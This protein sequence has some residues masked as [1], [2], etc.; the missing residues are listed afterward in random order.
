MM[1]RPK[2]QQQFVG[3]QDALIAG[4]AGRRQ[5]EDDAIGQADVQLAADILQPDGMKFIAGEPM[6][7]ATNF[8]AGL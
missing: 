4:G 5:R 3:A 7:L 2:P 1:L 8:V 6:K